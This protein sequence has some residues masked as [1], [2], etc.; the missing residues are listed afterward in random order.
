MKN[1]KKRKNKNEEHERGA[2]EASTETKLMSLNIKG[3]TKSVRAINSSCKVIL[4]AEWLD[5][6]TYL[7]VFV[8]KHDGQHTTGDI[9]IS[10]VR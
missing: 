6:C 10:W 1:Q 9:G 2:A 3:N 4:P 7:S 5:E 8:C